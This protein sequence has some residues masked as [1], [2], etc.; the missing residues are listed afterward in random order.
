MQ[1]VSA[2]NTLL[3]RATAGAGVVEEITLG[4]G[5]SFSGTTLNAAASGTTIAGGTQNV[6]SKFNATGDNVIDSSITDG[7]NSIYIKNSK[8]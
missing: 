8:H 5:L 3:G 4:T 7:N 6:L 2:T 1:N